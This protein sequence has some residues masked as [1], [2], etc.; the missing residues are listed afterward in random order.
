MDNI[1]LNRLFFRVIS[2]H[3]VILQLNDK[4]KTLK[5]NQTRLDEEFKKIPAGDLTKLNEMQNQIDETLMQIDKLEQNCFLFDHTAKVLLKKFLETETTKIKQNMKILN[6][7]NRA[8]ETPPNTKSS[9]ASC[10][11]GLL[12]P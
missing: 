4:I 12:S 8:H 9:E 5:E 10:D 6:F 7:L 11:E 2:D 1:D 3:N